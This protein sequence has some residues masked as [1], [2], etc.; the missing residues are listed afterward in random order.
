MPE[1]LLSAINIPKE[2]YNQLIRESE[3]L[4]MIK[5][6]VE[7]DDYIST[8]ELKVFLGIEEQEQKEGEE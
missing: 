3:R 6:I 4:A 1:I 8:K 5:K 7:K 2:E